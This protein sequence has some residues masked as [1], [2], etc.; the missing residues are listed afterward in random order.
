VPSEAKCEARAEQAERRV[1]PSDEWARREDG[2]CTCED[3]MGSVV[4]G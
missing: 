4:R 3:G 2:Q 1:V